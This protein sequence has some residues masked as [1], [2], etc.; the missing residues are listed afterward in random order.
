MDS[1]LELTKIKEVLQKN[2]SIINR[3]DGKSIFTFH[4]SD[5]LILNIKKAQLSL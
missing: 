1:A 5:F 4:L 3:T 2:G